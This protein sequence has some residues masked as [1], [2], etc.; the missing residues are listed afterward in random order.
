[1]LFI[2]IK[3][4]TLNIKLFLAVIIKAENR[5]MLPTY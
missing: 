1:M 5:V 2:L 3:N 4:N